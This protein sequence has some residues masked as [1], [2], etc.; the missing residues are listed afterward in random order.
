MA[1]WFPL[2]L[3]DKLARLYASKDIQPRQQGWV[4]NNGTKLMQRTLEEITRTSIIRLFDK[5]ND[6]QC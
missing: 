4:F 5:N 2:D 6:I 1:N 3:A